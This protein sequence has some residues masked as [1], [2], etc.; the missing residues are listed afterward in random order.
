MGAVGIVSP[1]AA[2]AHRGGQAASVHEFARSVRGHQ[3]ISAG[4]RQTQQLGAQPGPR[5]AAHVLYV[6]RPRPTTAGAG[7]SKLIL[8]QKYKCCD[9]ISERP[10]ELQSSKTVKSYLTADHGMMLSP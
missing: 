2:A 1:G 9:T 10:N 8:P 7:A 4:L 6:P 3:E 5:V